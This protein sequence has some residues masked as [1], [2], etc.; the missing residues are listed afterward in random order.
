[1]KK[2]CDSKNYALRSAEFQEVLPIWQDHLWPGR[3]SPIRAVSPIDHSLRFQSEINSAKPTFWKICGKHDEIT[4][5]IS[6][7]KTATGHYR[8]R[9]LFVKREFRGMGFSNQLLSAVIEQGKTEG[10]N[11][12]WSLPRQSAWHA[13]ERFGFVR[14]SDWLQEGMEFG[15]NCLAFYSIGS[16]H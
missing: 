11:F 6:G 2:I 8:S 10:C 5:V 14:T 9:G 13:Y 12:V 15:P 7:Y 4:G 3:K 1:M 16:E